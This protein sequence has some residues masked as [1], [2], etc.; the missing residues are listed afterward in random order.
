MEKLVLDSKITDL[1]R[2]LRVQFLG[3]LQSLRDISLFLCGGS[4]P[5]E[6]KFRRNLGRRVM[7]MKSKYM[8]SVYYP[9]DM[10]VELV[11]GHQRQDLLSLENLLADSVHCVT[12][13]LQSPGTFT[14]L[15]AFAN[16]ER[17]RDKL[18]VVVDPRYRRSRSFISIGP[19][20]YLESQTKS[21]VLYS[22]MDSNNLDVLTK[23]L[24]EATRDI[25]KNFSP[26]RDLSNPISSYKFYMA[27]IYVFDP[28][29]KD[30]VFDIL[31][32]IQSDRQD[33]AITAARTVLNSLISERKVIC[34]EENLSITPSGIDSL[35]YDNRT[36]KRVRASLSL[37]S[38][39]RLEAL[40]LTLRKSYGGK[41]ARR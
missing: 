7:H 16:Y 26:T 12:I 39:L 14:E 17:L 2:Q 9:E 8:Y 25:A 23:Q 36:K 30:L 18:I 19:I 20:R 28:I 31:R 24:T 29:P 35:I 6:A 10:F 37:L 22:R 1:A 40:N 21:K 13:L 11:L 38:E 41:W 5:E 34:D 3:G 27:L 4:S 32:A 15:G 33:I